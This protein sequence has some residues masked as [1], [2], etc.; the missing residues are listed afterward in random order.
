[1]RTF[2][3]EIS[4]P[5]ALAPL[6][7]PGQQFAFAATQ[8][9]NAGARLDNFADDLVVFAP[10]HIGYEAAEWCFKRSHHSSA[11]LDAPLS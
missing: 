8:I 1:L 10:E 9:E 2:D 5:R 4:T 11:D 6:R 3:G 7:Q